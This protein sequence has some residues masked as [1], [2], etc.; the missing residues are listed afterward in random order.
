MALV[1]INELH[2]GLDVRVLASSLVCGAVTAVVGAA[3]SGISKFA[4]FFSFFKSPLCDPLRT[5]V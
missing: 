1:T 4:S 5:G 3:S 2:T